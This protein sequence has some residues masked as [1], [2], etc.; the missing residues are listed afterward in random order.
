M[1]ALRDTGYKKLAVAGGV[2]ANAHIRAAFETEC[3]KAGAALYLPPLNLCGDNGA[4][5]ACQGYYEYLAGNLAGQELNAVASLSAE[6]G[7]YG[8]R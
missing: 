1:E 4:M 3:R 5:I 7:S 8:R 2:A 6:D